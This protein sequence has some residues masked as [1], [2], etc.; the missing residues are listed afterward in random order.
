MSTNAYRNDNTSAILNDP[1]NSQ[2]VN[3][4]CQDCF[5]EYRYIFPK[6]VR[7]MGANGDLNTTDWEFVDNDGDKDVILAG[8]SDNEGVITKLYENDGMGGFSEVTS[9]SFEGI[10]SGDID[11]SDISDLSGI[12]VSMGATMAKLVDKKIDLYKKRDKLMSL[13]NIDCHWKTLG[14]E[15]VQ[16]SDSLVQRISKT[17]AFNYGINSATNITT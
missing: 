10:N 1:Y 13:S 12:T 4:N 15:V 2:A 14:L 3:F 16:V 7:W 9:L 5:Q 17:Q 6:G 8:N 11:F